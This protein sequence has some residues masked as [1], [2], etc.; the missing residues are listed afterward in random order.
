MFKF[1]RDNIAPYKRPRIIEFITELPKTISGKIK[2]NELR[3]KEKELRRKNQS[4]ENEYFEEDF[5][6]K[7]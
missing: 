2:R 4:K 7:L 1:I 3:E 6:E 5:R